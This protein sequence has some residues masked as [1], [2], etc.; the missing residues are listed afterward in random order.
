NEGEIG[1]LDAVPVQKSVL[2]L[3]A[4]PIHR[5][6]VHLEERVDVRRG[7]LAGHHVLGDLLAHDR[8]RL[9]P[10][11][12]SRLEGD[13]GRDG[14]GGNR[15]A[16]GT[17]AFQIGQ[18][19]L[20]GD[21]SRDAAAGESGDVHVVLSRH[22]AHQGRGAGADSFLQGAGGRP[23]RGGNGRGRRSG[24]GCR[25][26]RWLGGAGGSRCGAAR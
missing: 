10:R 24:G 17:P 6:V 3:S 16:A 18:E 9:H 14:G 21:A 1:E 5:A 26:S 8:E 20:L 25:G 15:C 11:P 4:N 12:L 19:I 7:P 22:A 2:L 13:G 23:G